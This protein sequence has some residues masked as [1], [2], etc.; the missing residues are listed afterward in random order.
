MVTTFH[1]T[2]STLIGIWVQLQNF[3]QH[4]NYMHLLNFKSYLPVQAERQNR[5][6]RWGEE[7]LNERFLTV[8]EIITKRRQEAMRKQGL[9]LVQILRVSQISVFFCVV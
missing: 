6:L 3:M 5:V 1:K 8:E 2:H 9:Q 7:D 4:Q